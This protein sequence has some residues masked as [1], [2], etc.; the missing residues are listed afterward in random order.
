MVLANLAHQE[1]PVLSTSEERESDEMEIM[2]LCAQ[3]TTLDRIGIKRFSFLKHTAQF[4]LP[5]TSFF[6][7][8]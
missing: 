1:K 4:P 8:W 7:S 3:G 5:L 2:G 6:G